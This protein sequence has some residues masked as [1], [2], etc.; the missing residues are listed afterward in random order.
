M[1]RNTTGDLRVPKINPPRS[2]RMPTLPE[3]TTEPIMSAD[4]EPGDPGSIGARPGSGLPKG[5]VRP[6]TAVERLELAQGMQL[7]CAFSA[8]LSFVTGVPA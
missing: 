6:M 4:A 7:L 2:S 8:R 1:Y 3:D 5:P